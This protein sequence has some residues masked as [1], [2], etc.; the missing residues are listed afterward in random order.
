M[1]RFVNRRSRKA[2]L[3]PGSLIHVGEKKAEKTKITIIDY[4]G[5]SFR[6]K[7]VE[8]LTECF[9][10][11]ET[12]TVTWINIDGVHDPGIIGR[13]GECYGVHPLILEDIMNTAQRP[14]LEDM[15]DY[16]YIV[17]RMLSSAKGERRGPVGAGQP[18]RRPEFRHLL[19]GGRQPG[20]V[21]DPV[22][23]RIRTG[24]G[25]IRKMGPDFLAYSLVDA[26]VDNY[27]GV[28]EKLGGQVEGLEE[29][30]VTDPGQKTLHDIHTLKREMIYLRKSVW[31]LRE[32]ISGLQRA[33]SPLI[34]D[35]TGIFL[36][37]VYDHT[38]QV[39]DTIETYR[40]MLS[41]MLD[42]Y[43]SSVSNRMNQVMKVLTII[44][45]I[46]IPLTFLAGVYG[47]NFK[48]MPE[49]A[50]RYGYFVVLGDD[51]GHRHHHGDPFS[52]ARNG[53]R[54]REETS[55]KPK[56]IVLI[57]LIALLLVLIIQNSQE[58]VFRVLFWRIS[59]P[60]IVFV[61][62]AVVLGFFLGYF[63]G[64]SDRKRKP[65]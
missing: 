3:P 61:P 25:R 13:L 14:K 63:L 23:E 47:M 15:G 50:W 35:T 5:Q 53:C 32:V 60:Q 31:P 11:K 48:H 49:L 45:T 27:F 51:A 1:A 55:M 40:D 54:R 57:I 19:P 17:L 4:D 22:R 16:L 6:Q 26:I 24:K 12:A 46:F 7:D 21:F 65:V 43:L 2:G 34:K 59:A 62:L 8:D 42:M 56:I 29:E 33:E 52:N 64:R 41:G 36:R 10:F 28:L 44:S 38:I 39:I 9:V 30:L 18:D 20:D 58:T 37:D